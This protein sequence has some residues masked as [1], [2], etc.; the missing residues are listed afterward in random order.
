MYMICESGNMKSTVQQNS[1]FTA[2]KL[3]LEV[4]QSVCSTTNLLPAYHT[5]RQA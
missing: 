3:L 4:T 2:P 5:T 1:E